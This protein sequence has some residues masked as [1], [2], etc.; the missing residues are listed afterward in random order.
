RVSAGGA[1]AAPA[2]A[3]ALARAAAVALPRAATISHA[4]RGF[5]ARGTPEG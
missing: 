2:F 5:V 1:L 4:S 3:A